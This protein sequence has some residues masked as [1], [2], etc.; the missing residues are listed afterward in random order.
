M[1]TIFFHSVLLVNKFGVQFIKK[2]PTLDRTGGLLS[3]TGCY[4]TCGDKNK[5]IGL[6]SIFSHILALLLCQPLTLLLASTRTILTSL[7]YVKLA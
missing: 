1:G 7:T 5:L 2:L 3:L 4:S 6:D